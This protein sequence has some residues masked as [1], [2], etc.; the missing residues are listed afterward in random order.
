ML[1]TMQARVKILKT[2]QAGCGQ[3]NRMANLDWNVTG[4]SQSGRGSL[5]KYCECAWS[6]A[7]GQN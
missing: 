3:N 7:N 1:A 4:I 6:Q 5:T 2:A